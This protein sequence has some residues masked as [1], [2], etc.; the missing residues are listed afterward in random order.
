MKQTEPITAR[1]IEATPN[2]LILVLHERRVRIPWERC[3][4][5]L[6]QAGQTERLDAQLSPGGYGIHW[7]ALDEDLSVIGLIR[8]LEVAEG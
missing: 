5:K 2:A 4:S 1:Q 3:S 8:N 7:P 6:A